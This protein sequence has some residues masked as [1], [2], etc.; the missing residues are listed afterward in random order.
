MDFYIYFP[1]FIFE[2]FNTMNDI[3]SQIRS[4]LPK[5]KLR[6]PIARMAIFG[7][8]VRGDATIESDVDI[9]VSFDGSIGI[10][11]IDLADEL[12]K[13]LG[14]KVDLITMESI[15]PRQWDYLKNNILYV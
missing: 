8:Q 4:A 6:Y 3:Q 15:K 5:L 10:E 11:F 14:K 7:S 1:T 9:L 13:I 12:E 2:T